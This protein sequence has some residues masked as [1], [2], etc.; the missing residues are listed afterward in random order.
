VTSRDGQTVIGSAGSYPTLPGVAGPTKPAGAPTV[1]PDWKAVASNK[2]TLL[3]DY[4]KI[5]GG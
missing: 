2:A 1:Y 4:G 5:F 3:R